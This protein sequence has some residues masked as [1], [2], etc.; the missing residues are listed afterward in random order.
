MAWEI[1]GKFGTIGPTSCFRLLPEPAFGT[2]L[3]GMTANSRKSFPLWPLYLVL[4]ANE[5]LSRELP[6]KFASARFAAWNRWS[7]CPVSSG[8]SP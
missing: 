2:I 1:K 6:R 7:K 4:D 3:A 5:Q 8:I